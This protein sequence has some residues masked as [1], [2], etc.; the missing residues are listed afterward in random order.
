M[1]ISPPYILRSLFPDIIWAGDPNS[2]QVSLT[3]D[4]GPH[5]KFTPQFLDI[6]KEFKVKA[7]FFLI[8][9]NAEKF[10]RLV[11]RIKAE[12]HPIGNHSMSHRRLL[13]KSEDYIFQEILGAEKVIQEITGQRTKHFRPPYGVFDFRLMKILKRLNYRM[14]MWSLLPYDYRDS[15]RPEEIT[16]RVIQNAEEGALI[17]LHDG[18]PN[19]WKPLRSL[20]D[21]LDSLM[22]KNFGFSTLNGINEL[23]ILK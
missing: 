15:I 9:N 14:M 4:D 6:L 16:Q 22:A 12:G 23:K 21:I 1:L 18:H 5:P 17:L 7:S 19:S 8:G 10:P 13:F 3:F 11:E 20:P 2:H